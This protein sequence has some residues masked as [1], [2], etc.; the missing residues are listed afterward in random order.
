MGNVIWQPQYSVD[1]KIID[2]QH[3]KLFSILNTL[4]DE[5]HGKSNDNA[6]MPAVEN[7]LLDLKTYVAFHFAEEEKFFKKFQYEKAVE[8]AAQ[9]HIY[10]EKI[11]ELHDR[12]LN[13][14][15]DME[16]E[17]INFLDEWILNHINIADKQYT[18][19]FHEHGLF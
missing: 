9:H 18:K 7:A 14:E 5:I 19:C 2:L 6:S 15:T 4:Y 11:N 10:A 1:V 17:I 13:G 8:H 3:Q 16:N 12:Y